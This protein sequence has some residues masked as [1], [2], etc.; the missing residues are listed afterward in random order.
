MPSRNTT[1]LA[2][3]LLA[4]N[5]RRLRAERSWSQEDLAL[6]ANLHRTFVA[7]VERRVRNISIDNVEKLAQALNVPV[8]QLLMPS[9]METGRT[10][11]EKA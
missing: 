1:G 10:Q 7:H 5:L 3:E 2:R 4:A 6:E 9:R 11:G 8:H